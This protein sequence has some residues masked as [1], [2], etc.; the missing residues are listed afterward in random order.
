[1]NGRRVGSDDFPERIRKAGAGK[2]IEITFFR[3]DDLQMTHVVLG[4]AEPTSWTVRPAEKPT[5]AQKA[6]LK[7]WLAAKA[8][9]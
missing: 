5:K 7:G 8:G 1:M 2:E 9:G 4:E 6:V 3:D